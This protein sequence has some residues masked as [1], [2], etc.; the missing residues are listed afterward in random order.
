MSIIMCISN[1][2]FMEMETLIWILVERHNRKTPAHAMFD[3]P[4]EETDWEISAV[5]VAL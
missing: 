4:S 3:I 2:C 5:N 1:R